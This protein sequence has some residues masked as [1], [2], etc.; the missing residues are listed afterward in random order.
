[1]FNENNQCWAWPF[2]KT[3]VFSWA[4]KY[5]SYGNRM[6]EIEKYIREN[7]QGYLRNS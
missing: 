6:Y 7:Y 4:V 5:P 2:P 3:P 1:M